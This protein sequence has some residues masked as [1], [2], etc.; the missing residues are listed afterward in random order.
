M[1]KVE[2]Y[3]FEDIIPSINAA[4]EVTLKQVANDSM[5][6]AEVL[7]PVDTGQLRSG[8]YTESKKMTAWLKND[9]T[10]ASFVEEGHFTSNHSWF[11]P[12]VFMGKRGVEMAAKKAQSIFNTNL[13]NI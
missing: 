7:T 13:G 8:W 9:T 10:Y 2:T 11:V 1:I 12:G 3:G 4:L 5:Q 6:Y